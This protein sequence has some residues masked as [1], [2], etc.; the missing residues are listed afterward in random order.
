MENPYKAK[1]KVHPELKD[2]HIRIANTIFRALIGA[3]LSGSE[4]QIVLFIIDRLWGWKNKE[5]KVVPIKQDD[6]LMRIN[7][8][9]KNLRESIKKLEKKQIIFVDRSEK[10][11]KFGFNK[12]FD[13]WKIGYENVPQNRVRKRTLNGYENVPQMGTKTYPKTPST[14]Y[15]S[16]RKDKKKGIKKSVPNTD[17]KIHFKKLKIR[18]EKYLNY[19]LSE[20][21]A[22]KMLY[23]RNENDRQIIAEN[24]KIFNDKFFTD[25][26]TWWNILNVALNEFQRRVDSRQVRN[27]SMGFIFSGLFGN[28]KKG[29]E[30]F[31][32]FGVLD[33]NIEQLRSIFGIPENRTREVQSLGDG[34]L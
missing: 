16:K 28:P 19:S 26:I 3:G 6:F 22:E 23:G 29:T 17:F 1:S 33:W 20:E 21:E 18:F 7:I 12:Y 34:L 14:P 27:W 2:G 13:T 24:V 4:Y 25:K 31:L 15:Y 32:I 30:P 8:V 5:A 11:N 9:K 10:I